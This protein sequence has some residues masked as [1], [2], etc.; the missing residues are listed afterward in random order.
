MRV[1]YLR[2]LPKD[3]HQEFWEDKGKWKPL[4]VWVGKGYDGAMLVAN[5]TTKDRRPDPVFGEVY[6][7]WCMEDGVRH[8]QGYA[9]KTTLQSQSDVTRPP[10]ALAIADGDPNAP[11]SSSSDSSDASDSSDKHKKHKKHKQDK[12]GKKDKKYKKEKKHKKDKKG[13]PHKRGRD[14]AQLKSNM[15]AGPPHTQRHS[16]WHTQATRSL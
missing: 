9:Q 6:R 16:R 11:D 7:V 12:K 5:S 13:K 3:S 15:S 8:H 1:W 14:E 10:A 2:T 4:S